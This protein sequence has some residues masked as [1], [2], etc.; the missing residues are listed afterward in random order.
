MQIEISAMKQK[1]NKNQIGINKS[2]T[3]QI[4]IHEIKW[5]SNRNQI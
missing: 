4:E 5:K 3:N 2:N 1:T